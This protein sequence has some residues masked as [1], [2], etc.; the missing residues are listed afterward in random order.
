MH[1]GP[2]F[3]KAPIQPARMADDHWFHPMCRDNNRMLLSLESVLKSKG[4]A[5]TH[6]IPCHAVGV[7]GFAFL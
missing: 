3:V 1:I 5:L 2:L 7:W 6:S 4:K